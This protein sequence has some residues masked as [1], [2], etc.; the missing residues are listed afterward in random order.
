MSQFYKYEK[1]GTYVVTSK[2]PRGYLTVYV[3][4]IGS[5]H[6]YTP[7]PQKFKDL[8]PIHDIPDHVL[9]EYYRRRTIALQHDPFP[10]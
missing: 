5:H 4:S 1:T 9:D 8:T 6:V 7:E 3:A 2:V 10:Y